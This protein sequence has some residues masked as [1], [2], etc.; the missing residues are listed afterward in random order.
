[1][2]FRNI[3]HGQL[4]GYKEIERKDVR[5]FGFRCAVCREVGCRMEFMLPAQVECGWVL[6]ELFC[7]AG[8][9]YKE[10]SEIKKYAETGHSTM[11]SFD[12]LTGEPSK[13]EA[14]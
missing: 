6:A 8:T 14:L 10:M 1:M 2:T 3:I 13:S 11:T 9:R 5:F 7:R 12:F 4:F